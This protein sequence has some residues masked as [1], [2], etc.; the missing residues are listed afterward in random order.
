MTD[1]RYEC[2]EHVLPGT[3]ASAATRQL[4]DE[5]RRADAAMAVRFANLKMPEDIRARARVWGIE[6]WATVLWNNA[7]QCGY[8]E[9]M[10]DHPTADDARDDEEL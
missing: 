7:F 8:R 6:A 2:L 4:S 1:Q 3:F 9:A 10:R 5:R